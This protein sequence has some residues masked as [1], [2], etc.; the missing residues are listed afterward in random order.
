MVVFDQRRSVMGPSRR[1]RSGNGAGAGR[2]R[3]RDG[4]GDMRPLL[5]LR[6]EPGAAA[7]AARAA[8][9]GLA[10][11]V[12]PLFTIAPVAWAPPDPALFDSLLLTSANALRHAGPA[13]ALYH[14]LPAFAVGTATAAAARAAGFARVTAG[15]GDAAAAAALAVAAGAVRLLHLAGREHRVIGAERAIVYAADPVTVLPPAAVAALA[16][17]A[18]A[19][20]HSPR[21]AALLASLAT[22][23]PRG[24]AAVAAISPAAAAAAGG[25]WRAV[26]AAARPADE[27]LLAV[28]AR[29]CDDPFR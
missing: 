1:I 4:G 7:T 27:A 21:A 13:L 2:P 16:E 29:L 14:H 19:L 3:G 6:P 5:I 11:V 10:P 23:H 22:P 25:G 26:V 8:A 18:V 15:A 24:Q 28:A 20:V 9:L 17:G 12:A